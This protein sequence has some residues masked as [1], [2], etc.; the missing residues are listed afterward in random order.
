MNDTVGYTKDTS[1]NK[2]G[3]EKEFAQSVKGVEEFV[4]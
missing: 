1:G 3:S 2:N 4:I